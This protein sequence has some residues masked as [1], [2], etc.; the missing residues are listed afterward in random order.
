VI[1]QGKV[2]VVQ[3]VATRDDIL[4]AALNEIVSS[5]VAKTPYE[6]IVSLSDES[7]QLRDRLLERLIDKDILRREEHKVLWVISSPHY[8]MQDHSS[9]LESRD[10][11][12]AAVLK[13][14][15]PDPRTTALISLVKAC[16]LISV[17][18]TEEELPLCDRR[19][20]EI[21]SAGFVGKSV[22]DV[23]NCIDESMLAAIRAA[24]AVQ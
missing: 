3:R 8:P 15:R 7:A 9:E 10:R 2:V 18:F 23:V 19:I 17:V 5:S 13:G 24:S 12:R 1:D 14:K 16:K 21:I 20:P 4:D 11:I 6:W 22:T